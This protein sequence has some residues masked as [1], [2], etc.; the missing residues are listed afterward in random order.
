MLYSEAAAAR[1]LGDARKEE[2]PARVFSPLGLLPPFRGVT[3]R[4]FQRGGGRRRR[5]FYGTR[6][7]YLVSLVPEGGGKLL[8]KL[9]MRGGG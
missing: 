9:P 8:Q 3:D 6:V 7:L 5:G 4:D 2:R 1:G